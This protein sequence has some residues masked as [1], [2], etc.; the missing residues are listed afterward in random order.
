MKAQ[1]IEVPIEAT[2]KIS[3]S[4]VRGCLRLLEMYLDDHPSL[5]IV[6]SYRATDSGMVRMLELVPDGGNGENAE[7]WMPV[8]EQ[9]P[10]E[11]GQYLVSCDTDYGVEVGRF[12]IDEDGERYF[13]CDWNDPDDIN[14]WMPL[15]K[16]YK[17]GEQND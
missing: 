5:T 17:R 6:D 12:Y 4:T 3:A 8:T 16:P 7:R 15:P 2:M 14:A 13:G 10:E 1:T 9:L 11:E